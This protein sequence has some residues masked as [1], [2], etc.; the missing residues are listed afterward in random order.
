MNTFM[1]GDRVIIN[2]MDKNVK[3]GDTVIV[4][5]EKTVLFD[6]NGDLEICDGLHETVAK[7]VIATEGQ[8]INIDF[9]AGIVYID[10]KRLYEDY[11]ELGLTHH[12][13]NAFDYPVTVP[14]GYVFIMG[15]NR[16]VS[17]DSRSDVIG[18]VPVEDITGKILLKFYPDFKTKF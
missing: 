10:N 18:F 15:D 1:D 16:S 14:E 2:V 3:S 7:R 17:L 13:G 12:N 6:D 4:N 9:S 5:L 11:V 8:T